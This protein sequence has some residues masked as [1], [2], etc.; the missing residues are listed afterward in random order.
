MF[1]PPGKSIFA[2]ASL[3]IAAPCVATLST[4]RGVR[5]RRNI[6]SAN[7]ARAA[8]TSGSQFLPPRMRASSTTAG[9]ARC[10]M[11]TGSLKE[12]SRSVRGA[13]DGP[14]NSCDMP[15]GSAAA[16]S[17]FSFSSEPARPDAVSPCAVARLASTPMTRGAIKDNSFIAEDELTPPAFPTASAIDELR[18]PKIVPKSCWPELSMLAVALPSLKRARGFSAAAP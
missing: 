10:S 12:A 18:D 13:T 1:A 16:T 15:G 8:S 7:A 5:A 3:A 4:P 14:L 17:A 11:W 2:N 9:S 6:S